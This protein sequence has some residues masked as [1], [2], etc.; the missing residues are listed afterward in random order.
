MLPMGVA[1]SFAAITVTG[2]SAAQTLP[3]PTGQAVVSSCKQFNALLSTVG[4]QMEGSNNPG[5]AGRT[6]V[7]FATRI[8]ASTPLSETRLTSNVQMACVRVMMSGSVQIA[9]LDSIALEWR[10]SSVRTRPCGLQV[11]DWNRHVSFHEQQHIHDAILITQY[12]LPLVNRPLELCAPNILMAET[13]IVEHLN[14]L[15][16]KISDAAQ[17]EFDRRSATFHQ[18]IAGAPVRPLDCSIC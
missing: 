2:I 12:F 1:A 17:R 9:A 4:V 18:T 8:D 5:T 14:T 15:S 7:L 11:L 10:P 16:A 13:A 3:A 6:K